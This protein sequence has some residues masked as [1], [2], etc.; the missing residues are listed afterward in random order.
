M[1]TIISMNLIGYHV[2][3]EHHNIS[4]LL[5]QK[6]NDCGDSE[7]FVQMSINESKTTS[8]EVSH[9]VSLNRAK[10]QDGEET[11]QHD[12]DDDGFTSENPEPDEEEGSE[13]S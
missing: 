10:R 11:S 2:H 12:D 8:S 13:K 5:S 7:M 9:N 6:A 4:Q 1:L 3:S